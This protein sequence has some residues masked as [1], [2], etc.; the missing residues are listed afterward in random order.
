MGTIEAE[1]TC[2]QKIWPT[3]TDSQTFQKFGSDLL[4]IY[5]EEHSQITEQA[6]KLGLKARRFTF[7]DGD[8]STPEGQAALWKVLE[9]ERPREVWM[10][11]ECKY[12][13][14]FSR[15][16]M[17]RSKSTEQMISE[18][19]KKQ[20]VHLKLCNDVYWYQM[21]CGGQFHL[22]QPQG[23][24][25]I[26]QPEVYDIYCGTL[27]TVFDMCEVG[28]LLAPH[29]MRRVS[30]N[31]FL[32]KRTHVYTS[33]K[34]F[35][36]AF[37]HRLCPGHHKHAPIAGKIYHLGRWISLSEYAARYTSGFGRN[38][39]RYVSCRFDEKPLVLDELHVCDVDE[40]FVAGV[41][42]RKEKVS[43]AAVPESLEE[44]VS[45]EVKR[46]RY[47]CKQTPAGDH[48][49]A[50]GEYWDGIFKK[51]ET[52]VP[53]VGKRVLDDDG[54]LAQIQKGAPNLK[55]QRVEACRGTERLRLP[56]S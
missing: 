15:R 39:A 55:V 6:C 20:R 42:K 49:C 50:A 31:N 41:V 18:G 46:P 1:L 4:E 9:E 43:A 53:R 33:S 12:W 28:K 37:D 19:R 29:V 32:R 17:G 30:G 23:S 52:M 22:E 10:A 24:E 36:D 47:H 11:P 45:A 7:S 26:Y 44:P 54:V 25:L 40:A 13:G 51:I 3:L 38:V 5:C 16:N 48:G 8:L 27:C 34:I 21:D 14:N 35:H 2:L 56:G